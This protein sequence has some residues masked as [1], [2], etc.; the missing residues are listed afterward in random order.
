MRWIYLLLLFLALGL[1]GAFPALVLAYFFTGGQAAIAWHIYALGAGILASYLPLKALMDSR[2]KDQPLNIIFPKHINSLAVSFA[3]VAF[4]FLI[5]F[6]YV[7]SF[8]AFAAAIIAYSLSSG[9]LPIAVLVALLAQ[10]WPLYQSAR[11]EKE[12]GISNTVFQNFS[13][14]TFDDDMIINAQRQTPQAYTPEILILPPLIEDAQADDSD[15][16]G[17]YEDEDDK[18]SSSES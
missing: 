15:T 11:R 4:L 8:T 7:S 13:F 9:S 14:T 3:F 17:Y 18:S 10:I 1:V 6:L 2:V 16:I 5:P 12:L